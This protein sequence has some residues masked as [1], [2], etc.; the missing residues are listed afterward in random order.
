M[1]NVEQNKEYYDQQY[2][3]HGSGKKACPYSVHDFAKAEYRVRCA[4]RAFN[5]RVEP[6][7][8][9]GA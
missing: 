3:L 7:K 1:F 2:E 9:S 5:I 6:G 4:L 8:N